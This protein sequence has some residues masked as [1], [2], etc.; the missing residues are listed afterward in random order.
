MNMIL[1]E[2]ESIKQE[3]LNARLSRSFATSTFLCRHLCCMEISPMHEK[4]IHSILWDARGGWL[5]LLGHFRR[6]YFDSYNDADI[7]CAVK[8]T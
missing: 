3:L 2:L 6:S 4:N 1:V 8:A 5:W 7:G